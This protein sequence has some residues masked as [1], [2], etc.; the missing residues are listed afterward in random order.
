MISPGFSLT[1]FVEAIKDKTPPE[2][3]R[4]SEQEYL[5]IKTLLRRTNRLNKVY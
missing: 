2:V 5:T 1:E 4:I 3:D